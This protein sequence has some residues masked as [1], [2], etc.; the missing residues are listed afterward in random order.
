MKIATKGNAIIAVNLFGIIGTLVVLASTMTMAFQ[1]IL[2]RAVTLHILCQTPNLANT[3]CFYKPFFQILQEGI[4][5]YDTSIMKTSADKAKKLRTIS[6]G[7]ESRAEKQARL[8]LTRKSMT[9]KEYK[10]YLAQER[11]TLGSGCR[12]AIFAD[13]TKDV[14]SIRRHWKEECRVRQSSNQKSKEKFL[15]LLSFCQ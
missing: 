1:S 12:S 7:K 6:V 4:K 10:E 14:K 15:A 11:S 8:A 3:N 13:K 9:K 2:P 5:M